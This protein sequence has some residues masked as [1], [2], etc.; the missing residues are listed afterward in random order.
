MLW[1]FFLMSAFFLFQA[2]QTALAS[3]GGCGFNAALAFLAC[4]AARE[5][6]PGGNC[7]ASSTLALQLF[8]FLIS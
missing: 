5:E 1:F 3:N 4:Q 6:V 7:G 2:A 8:R